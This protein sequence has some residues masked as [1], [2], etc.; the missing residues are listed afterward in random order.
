MRRLHLNYLLGS[1]IL[2]RPTESDISTT[3]S[4]IN[5]GNL[6]ALANLAKMAESG[7][8]SALVFPDGNTPA[9]AGAGLPFLPYEPFTACGALAALTDRIGLVASVPAT[10]SEP[11]NVARR[12]ATLDH[13][14]GGRMGWHISSG[15]AGMLVQYGDN[16][17]PAA[18]PSC[19]RASEFVDVVQRLWGSWSHDA[20][21]VGKDGKANVDGRLNYPITHEGDFFRVKGPLD[22]P[23]P[24]Q[25]RPV[26]FQQ[27]SSD[28]EKDLAA[29][30]A[31]IAIPRDLSRDGLSAFRLDMVKRMASNGREAGTMLIMPVLHPQT[32]DTGS[33]ASANGSAGM[34][35]ADTLVDFMDNY[36]NLRL[37]EGFSLAG[38]SLEWLISE[39]V[40]RL[41][42]K[43]L[44]TDHKKA[45]TLREN[46]GLTEL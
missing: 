43:G 30:Y 40:P 42:S 18:K 24:P 1:D 25:G 27:I 6:S 4:S 11:F 38:F 17:R 15:D 28:E 35:D 22:V 23:R 37:I 32:A 36:F 3:A 31:D 41:Q 5:A 8:F 45:T 21:I 34:L 16:S 12:I 20:I 9:A 39:I 2:P 29:L 14:S 33:S 13:I 19:D 44:L 26:L 46:F 7:G 10:T